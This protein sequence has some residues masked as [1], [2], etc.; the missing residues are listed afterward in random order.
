LISYETVDVRRIPYLDE[1]FDIVAL[2]SVLGALGDKDGCMRPQRGAVS[3]IHRV[4]KPGGRFLFAE[5]M[6]GSGV[7]TMLRRRFVPW[8]RE[9]RYF[10]K[11][12]VQYLLSDFETVELSFRGF[13]A[14]FGRREWQ[15]RLLH[16]LDLFLVPLLPSSARYVGFGVA[17]KKGFVGNCDGFAD[18]RL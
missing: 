3:E 13:L 5:N 11:E 2:K 15:R 18:S 17:T 8:G 4:L 10:S 12:E 14:A 9:W 1:Q 16:G 7:H 6:R